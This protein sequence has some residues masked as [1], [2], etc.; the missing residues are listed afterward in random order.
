MKIRNQLIIAA[1]LVFICF[2]VEGA[3]QSLLVDIL[4]KAFPDYLVSMTSGKTATLQRGET[5]MPIDLEAMTEFTH[6]D[7][8]LLAVVVVFNE[9][10]E[11]LSVRFREGE[12]VE[13]PSHKNRLLLVSIADPSTVRSVVIDDHALGSTRHE[14]TIKDMIGDGTS[15]LVL[16]AESVYPLYQP[17]EISIAQRRYL[18]TLPVLDS[19]VEVTTK[20][21]LFGEK[22]I[23]DIDEYDIDF[24]AGQSGKRVLRSRNRKDGVTRLIERSANGRFNAGYEPWVKQ[25]K[26]ALKKSSLLAIRVIDSLG[27][28]ISQASINGFTKK[29]NLLKWS[30][31]SKPFKAKTDK[32]GG[33][34]IEPGD[35]VGLTVKAEGYYPVEFFWN[36]E[37]VPDDVAL[38]T[39][40]QAGP[41]VEMIGCTK[42][43]KIW[44]EDVA[45]LSLGVRLIDGDKGKWKDVPTKKV[46]A[47]DLWVEIE[48]SNDISWRQWNVKL[49]GK[50][51]WQLAPG[52][53]KDDT[54]DGNTMHEAPDEGYKPELKY[55]VG[56][57]PQGFYLRSADGKRYGKVWGFR[58]EDRSRG[59]LIRRYMWIR[60]AVQTKDTGRRSLN[61]K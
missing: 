32:R 34:E 17:R 33:F 4:Q 28:P 58:F 15:Q 19:I 55:K 49:S 43:R 45:N 26:K 2:R 50:K 39:L 27:D 20:R 1:L 57:C 31:K 36:P 6:A 21:V 59:N 22:G 5:T 8:R 47:A 51:G 29:L 60:F 9:L 61:P 25:K 40:E 37:D 42:T 41:A 56:E 7:T 12:D 44:E 54:S 38:I 48:K 46:E 23:G 30:D 11:G 3:E 13:L 14:I 53:M 52:S 10:Q 35:G 24:V 16:A 18:Y